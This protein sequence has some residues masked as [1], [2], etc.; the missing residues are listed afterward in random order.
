MRVGILPLARPTFDMAFAQE[1]LDAMLAL[2][3][4]RGVEIVGARAPLTDGAQADAALGAVLEQNPNRVLVLQATFTDAAFIARA[5][6]ATAAP[7]ALWAPREPRAGGRLR[8]NAFCGL[9]LAGHALGLAGRRFGWLLADPD[10]AGIDA[11]LAD[12]LA[13]GRDVRPLDGRPARAAAGANVLEGARVVRIGA[14]PE[15]FDTCRHD[16]ADTRARLG[17]TVEEIGL[18]TL[19]DAARA[20]DGAAAAALRARAQAELG[21]L[22]AVDQAQLDRSLRLKLALDALKAARGADAFAVRCWPEAFTEYGGAVCGPASMMAEGRAPCACE[23][24]VWGAATQLALQRVA[25]APVFLADLV[26]MDAGDDSGVVWHCG[27]AP[28]SMAAGPARATIHSNRRMPLLCEFALKPG[29]VTFFRLSQAFGRPRAVIATG[30]MLDRP[31]AFTGT[32]GV[33]RFDA[34]AAQ[35]LARVMDAGLEH[36]MALAYGDHA[37]ALEALAAALDLP[38][39]NLTEQA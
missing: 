39:L 9:N 22:D 26:D 29:R 1:K 10:E 14:P 30:A 8:L 31:G 11:A 34:P 18:D 21:G 33:A 36:H 25:G 32:S 37:P 16:A 23:A 38:V 6:A 27:Q 13:G 24:D 28:L 12:L 35:V 4:A 20:A 3:A 17:V 7:L 19:F 2:L 5:A 15:G